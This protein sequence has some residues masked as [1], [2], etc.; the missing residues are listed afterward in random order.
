ML[1]TT[2][3]PLLDNAID[4]LQHGV[5]HYLVRDESPTAIKHAVLNI[6][7]GIELFLKE[8]LARVHPLL[9]Y[10]DIDKRVTADSQTIGLKEILVRME[11][12]GIPLAPNQTAILAE[13]Q[14]RRN[15]IEHHRFDP[16]ADH[17][18]TVGQALK[19]LL[20]FL[21]DHL[22]I[23]L[24]DIVEDTD[25]YNKVLTAIL[26]YTERVERAVREA[27]AASRLLVRCSDCG[28]KTVA[29][30]SDRGHYCYLCHTDHNMEQCERCG[31]YMDS[32][33]IDDSGLCS[34]CIEDI[35]R[36]P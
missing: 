36:R 30:D 31:E 6:Y 12:L 9:I 19:F 7:H 1:M 11:N 28:E 25:I 27:T 3:T 10:R 15:H 20:D 35:L 24:E 32:A 17:Q 14:K 29:V 34:D 21:P 22:G 23:A 5:A 2:S 18:I 26:S 16:S 4:S 13:L 33:N 8:R